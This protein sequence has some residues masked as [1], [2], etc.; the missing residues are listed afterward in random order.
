MNGAKHSYKDTPSIQQIFARLGFKKFP[1]ISEHFHRVQQQSTVYLQACEPAENQ[2]KV[3]RY[4]CSLVHSFST[5]FSCTG[6][7]SL[8][9]THLSLDYI[10][11]KEKNQQRYLPEALEML[12]I[13]SCICLS[14]ACT[15][16]CPLFPL[17]FPSPCMRH[18]AIARSL[19]QPLVQRATAA[20]TD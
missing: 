5:P 10:K 12:L 20:A 19:Q 7:P 3:T 14:T 1:E 11:R 17:P 2:W 6:T 4:K 9:S 8:S 18:A 13:H 15:C 16:A